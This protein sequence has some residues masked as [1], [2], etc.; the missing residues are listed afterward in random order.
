MECFDTTWVTTDHPRIAVGCD[1]GNLP[2]M[3]P[4]RERHAN[5]AGEQSRELQQAKRRT[6][7]QG[8]DDAVARPCVLSC[9][10]LGDAQGSP[11]GLLHRE[12]CAVGRGQPR[13]V[14]RAVT[15]PENAVR[16]RW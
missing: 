6:V 14:R 9:E 16:D 12:P 1:P 10:P 2:R 11:D 13:V 7:R 8:Y 3:Q 15:K 4:R 5:H